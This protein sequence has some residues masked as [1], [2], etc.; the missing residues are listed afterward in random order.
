MLPDRIAV[1]RGNRSFHV[2]LFIIAPCPTTR[3]LSQPMASTSAMR[4]TSRRAG[5]CASSR[6]EFI[7]LSSKLLSGLRTGTAPSNCRRQ[8]FKKRRGFSMG[9]LDLNCCLVH[10][11][12]AAMSI[13][14]S[15]ETRSTHNEVTERVIRTRT[16]MRGS[17]PPDRDWTSM[18][19][20]APADYLLPKSVQWVTSLPYAVRPFALANKYPRIANM[21]AIDWSRPTACRAYFVSLL[22]DSRGDRQGFPADVEGDLRRLCDYYLSR[23]PTMDE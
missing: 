2:G 3:S 15:R 5:A 1:H 9:G 14:R 20:A 22:V 21:L 11:A 7:Q 13:Y 19:K 12:W 10:Q 17:V 16:P 18:R 23:H 6:N 4:G 8:E